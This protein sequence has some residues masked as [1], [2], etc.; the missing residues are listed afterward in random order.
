M[1]KG[2]LRD[3]RQSVTHGKA[4]PAR[5]KG[6]GT[7]AGFR[8]PAYI[9]RQR[10][11]CTAILQQEHQETPLDGMWPRQIANLTPSARLPVCHSTAC[12]HA[13]TYYDAAEGSGYPGLNFQDGQWGVGLTGELGTNTS[14]T[15]PTTGPAHQQ[16][17]HTRVHRR[18]NSTSVW[19]LSIPWR[20][21]Y[22]PL[23]LAIG[24]GVVVTEDSASLHT[25][26]RG[27]HACCERVAS[28]RRPGLPGP[29]GL[30]GLPEN[31]DLSRAGLEVRGYD[32]TD[33]TIWLM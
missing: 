24:G 28:T 2:G 10:G 30:P 1:V 9:T 8:Q 12:R 19:L 11:K 26:T 5:S 20:T 29:P 27:R 32:P 16:G 4:G 14:N 13:C 15:G 7:K 17:S 25:V 23:R 33:P 3:E 31:V 21:R 6:K 18:A 22:P